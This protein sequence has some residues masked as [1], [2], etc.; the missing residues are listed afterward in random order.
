MSACNEYYDEYTLQK[1][2]P[3]Q[4]S[5]LVTLI[6]RSMENKILVIMIDEWI[7]SN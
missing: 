6:A 1:L 7:T 5:L 4:S 3:D 2:T